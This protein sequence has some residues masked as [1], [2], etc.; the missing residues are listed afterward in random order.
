GVY[1]F[2]PLPLGRPSAPAKGLYSKLGDGDSVDAVKLPEDL[3][4]YQ[5]SITLCNISPFDTTVRCTLQSA[6]PAPDS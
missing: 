1:D 3:Q 4:K 6:S 2:G 5:E